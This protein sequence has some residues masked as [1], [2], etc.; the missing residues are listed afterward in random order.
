MA[1]HISSVATSGIPLVTKEEFYRQ[2]QS[3]DLVFCC[4]R[5]T[6]SKV[7]EEMTISVFSHVLMTWLPE[8][9]DHWLTIEST[10]KNGVHIG[11]LASY[12]DDYHGDLVLARRPQVTK[13]DIRKARDAGLQALDDAYDWRQEL[14]IIGHRLLKCV[15]VEIPQN[16][17]YCSGLQY[18][19]S[20]ATEFPLQ[21][22]GMNYPTPEEVWTDPTVVPVC[23]L[24]RIK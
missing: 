21:R 19:M 8:D 24:K 9:A 6:I 12:I 3:G 5:A 14:S 4:G 23:G 2:V 1:L 15:P 13:T 20:L 18:M 17:Y 22:P 16:E 11:Q 10:A 7:I